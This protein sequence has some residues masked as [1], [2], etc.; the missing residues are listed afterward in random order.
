MHYREEQQHHRSDDFS[1]LAWEEVQA[2]SHQDTRNIRLFRDTPD[3]K[4]CSRLQNPRKRVA[5][6]M[7]RRRA[8]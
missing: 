4:T 6:Y 3:R 1:H 2:R 7:H 8:P 5:G